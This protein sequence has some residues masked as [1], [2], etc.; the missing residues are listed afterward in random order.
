VAKGICDLVNRKK[1]P[2]RATTRGEGIENQ[3]KTLGQWQ[4]VRKKDVG[5]IRS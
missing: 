2:T 5:R 1:E 3:E 4:E